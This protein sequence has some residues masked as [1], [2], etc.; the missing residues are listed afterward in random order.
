MLLTSRENLL[1]QS[2]S[3]KVAEAVQDAKSPN[4]RRA[5][6]AAFR[7]Y[8]QWTQDQGLP[9]W[10]G[11]PALIAEYAVHLFEDHG[12]SVT[13]IRL[14]VTA[15]RFAHET[16]GL[17]NPCTT[18]LVRAAIAGLARRQ[19]QAGRRQKQARPLDSEALAAIRATALRPRPGRSGHEEK[20]ETAHRRG[21]VDIALAYV[22]SNGGLRRSEAAALTWSDVQPAQNGAGVILVRQSKTDAAGVG[23]FVA[24]SEG[25]MQ[26]LEAIR[27][28]DAGEGDPVFGLSDRQICRRIKAAAQAAG[29]GEGYSGHS[30][31]VGMA[32]KYSRRGAP[33][34]LIQRQGRWKSPGM[35]AHYTRAEKAEAALPYQ[36]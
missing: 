18:E 25:T 16:A 33:D 12:K 30:G 5:Y 23:E 31:R 28:T 13:S 20:K 19:V 14:A 36:D 17:P 27:P 35:V 2:P 34:S 29:L 32:V 7:A 11:S 9:H 1:P 6:R 8:R 3:P 26:A 4:T 24:I 22:L 21:A 15:V 10:Q